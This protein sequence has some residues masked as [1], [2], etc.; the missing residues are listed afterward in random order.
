MTMKLT[1]N[2]IKIKALYVVNNVDKLRQRKVKFTSKTLL[3]IDLVKRD[4]LKCHCC[5]TENIFFKEHKEHGLVMY[6]G[7][8]KNPQRMTTDHD[9]LNSLNGSDFI[10]N[11]H[12][13]CY[14]CNATRDSHFACYAEFKYWYDEA[15]A[16]GKDP[17]ELSKKL[18]K[19]FCY[20]DFDKNLGQLSNLHHLYTG[21]MPP[22][23][24]K[25]L[26]DNYKK[27]G[28]FSPSKMKNQLH[29]HIQLMMR[30]NN[31]AW[32]EFLNEL[33]V[34]MIKKKYGVT[35]NNPGVNFS[36]M[37]GVSK[38]KGIG[39]F[40]HK[41]QAAVNTVVNKEYSNS[42]IPII[43]QRRIER[44]EKAKLKEDKVLQEAK[45]VQQNYTA[46][47]FWQKLKEA[48]KVLTA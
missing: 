24:K 5:G 36:I 26:T 38:E 9:L 30:F 25:S 1:G 41:V 12:L 47:S 39:S 2:N 11:Q 43:E 29:G 44:A 35:I 21:K 40:C 46:P 6:T 34:E 22:A 45:Q 10:E 32:S 27:F 48:F 20:I 18:Q 3:L 42:V 33:V 16:K 28:I 4:G 7:S 15:K 17:V 31:D 8:D 14:T 23:L 19:N 13:L 37:K